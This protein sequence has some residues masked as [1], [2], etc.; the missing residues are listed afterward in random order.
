MRPGVEGHYAG[1]G[2]GIWPC[3]LQWT[4]IGASI[5][6]A[7]RND[8]DDDDD[9]ICGRGRACGRFFD[10]AHVTRSTDDLISS[11]TKELLRPFWRIWSR[12]P[13]TVDD[14]G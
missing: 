1:R 4:G 13:P 8:D 3:D 10:R 7:G 11:A 12:E 9:A 5:G 6:V 2:G 14:G